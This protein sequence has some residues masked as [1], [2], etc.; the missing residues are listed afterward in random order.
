M[1]I[2]DATIEMS[3]GKDYEY[4]LCTYTAGYGEVPESTVEFLK[5]NHKGMVGVIANGSSNFK[6]LGLFGKSGDRISEKY[7]VECVRKLDMGG[8]VDD[9]K[10]VA[11]RCHNLLKLE[12]EVKYEAVDS[13]SS[14]T[15]G[16][17]QLKALW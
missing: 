10:D 12:T 13:I 8:T 16:K 11:K 1:S 17:F 2:E 7:G 3:S 6:S 5:G 4:I 9:V 15:N 14:Y